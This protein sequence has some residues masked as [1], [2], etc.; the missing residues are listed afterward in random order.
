MLDPTWQVYHGNGGGSRV[1]KQFYS[2]TSLKNCDGVYI[3]P[4]STATHC[5]T[6]QRTATHCNT[7]Q[8]TATHCN[9][10]QHTATHCN[11]LQHHYTI[12]TFPH[13]STLGPQLES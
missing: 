7:L 9:T 6:L 13:M 11:T 8:H 1:L 4:S 2:T 5:N 10:L 12:S 3:C